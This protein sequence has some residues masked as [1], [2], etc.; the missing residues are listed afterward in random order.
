MRMLA[1]T[2]GF[3]LLELLVAFAIMGMSLA[4]LYRVT[5]SSARNVGDAAQYQRA[6]VLAESLHGLRDSVPAQGWNEEGES[7]G[8][9]WKVSSAP[10][11]T[12]VARANLTAVALHE[13]VI[14]VSWSDGDRPRQVEVATLLPQNTQTGV[15]GV[16]R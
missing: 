1:R 8:F 7:G 14:L 2:R 13:V 10:H 16:P 9:R 12:P 5:G 4:M 15:P 11:P 3:S 6:L